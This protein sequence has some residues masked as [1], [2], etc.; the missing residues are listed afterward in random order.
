MCVPTLSAVAVTLESVLGLRGSQFSVLQTLKVRTF[1]ES[2]GVAA[3]EM[4]DGARSGLGTCAANSRSARRNRRSN[5]CA[6]LGPATRDAPG[7]ERAASAV[8]PSLNACESS[9]TLDA[10]C[11][12]T[13]YSIVEPPGFAGKTAHPAVCVGST[14]VYAPIPRET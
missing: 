10:D 9:G 5:C 13:R 7:A 6:T 3:A 12:T 2:T 1:P 8:P 4:R 14:A 11:G